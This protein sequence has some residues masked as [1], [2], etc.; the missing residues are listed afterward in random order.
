VEL[1]LIPDLRKVIDRYINMS[2]ILRNSFNLTNEESTSETDSSSNAFEE[3]L[4]ETRMSFPR[5]VSVLWSDLESMKLCIA[6]CEDC[7]NYFSSRPSQGY[8]SLYKYECHSEELFQ[9]G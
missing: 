7:G 8:W 3:F 9:S 5:K 1:S 6:S 4:R 2:V